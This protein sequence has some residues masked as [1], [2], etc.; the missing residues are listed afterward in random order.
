MS[1]GFVINVEKSSL[2]PSQ[3]IK[4]LGFVLDLVA[5]SIILTEDKKD[6]LKAL[7][8]ALQHKYETTITDLAQLVGTPV[9]SLPGVQFGRLHD[10]KLGIEKDHK[11]NYEALIYLS[12]SLHGNPVF[13]IRPDASKKGWGVYL[14][15]DTDVIPQDDDKI[16][17]WN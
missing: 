11:G 6:K 15:C 16:E 2:I 1:L 17:W 14:G 12:P 10:R 3:Q 5:M 9:S 4:F 7:L 8:K 13:E